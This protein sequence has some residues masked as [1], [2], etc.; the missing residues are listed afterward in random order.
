MQLI[1]GNL[2]LLELVPLQPTFES[3]TADGISSVCLSD[4][5]IEHEEFVV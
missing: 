4:N 1:V 5:G 3:S 2:D